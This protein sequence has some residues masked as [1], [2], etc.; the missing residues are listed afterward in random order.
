MRAMLADSPEFRLV[1]EAASGEEAVSMTATLRPDIVLLDVEMPGM[2]G[3]GTALALFQLE[4]PHP[5]VLAWTVSESTDDLIRMMRAGCAGY[6]LKD[7]GPQEL[8]RAVNAATR[9][10]TPVPR[11]LIPDVISRAP[12][13]LDVAAESDTVLTP[14]EEAILK[15]I[16]KGSS[17]KEISS[18]LGISRRSVET[19][20]SNIYR[21]LGVMSRGQAVREGLRQ[22]LLASIDF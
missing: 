11:R 1:G 6:I 17:S 7:V 21:K 5:I 10:D 20:L 2:S 3:Y 9:G 12:L 4:P 22:G 18:A 15:S 19:H 8:A 14:R 16:A 13:P